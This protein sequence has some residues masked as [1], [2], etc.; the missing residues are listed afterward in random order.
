M[1]HNLP[2]PT[3]KMQ[4]CEIY[5]TH[6]ESVS[7]LAAPLAIAV[8]LLLAGKTHSCSNQSGL[9]EKRTAAHRCN[10][11]HTW[12]LSC[13]E[14][15]TMIKDSTVIFKYRLI[16]VQRREEKMFNFDS[17]DNQIIY[18]DCVNIVFCQCSYTAVETKH[19]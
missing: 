17:F 2:E 11:P 5:T 14:K 13:R 15:T 9:I 3:S 1:L 19:I 10:S 16:A 12:R 6:M 7:P 18:L 4:Y 8:S